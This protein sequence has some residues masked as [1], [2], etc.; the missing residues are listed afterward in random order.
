MHTAIAKYQYLHAC[1]LAIAKW[2]VCIYLV[3]QQSFPLWEL[4]QQL[5]CVLVLA[6]SFMLFKQY[7]YTYM[8]ELA[9]SPSYIAM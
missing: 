2:L 3:L 5:M 8:Y 7:N 1:R 9:S 4:W 6:I